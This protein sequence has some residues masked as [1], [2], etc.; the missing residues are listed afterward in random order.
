LEELMAVVGLGGEGEG[1]EGG[2]MFVDREIE[3]GEGRG[4][5]SSHGKA[6]DLVED[7]NAEGKIGIID[8]EKEDGEEGIEV[9][10]IVIGVSGGGG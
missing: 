10:G 4:C 6:K 9:K 8:G 2:E 1:R 3:V 5:G 7:M